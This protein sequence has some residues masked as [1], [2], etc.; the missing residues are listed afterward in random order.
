MKKFYLLI[1]TVVFLFSS[2]FSK[3]QPPVTYASILSN[4][5]NY[6]LDDA[7]FW[8]GSPGVPPPNPCTNCTIVINSD[9]TVVPDNGTSTSTAYPSPGTPALSDIKLDGCILQVNGGVT[10]TVNTYIE[11][12]N[13]NLLIGSDPTTAATVILNDQADLIGTSTVQL[14]NINCSVNTNN[15]GTA[16]NGNTPNPING[17]H[18]DIGN[19]ITDVNPL[20]RSAGIFGIFAPPDASGYNYSYVLTANGIGKSAHF[21]ATQYSLNCD[22]TTSNVCAVGWIY[23]PA[24]TSLDPTY[25]VIFGQAATLPVVLVQFLATKNPDATIKLSWAT[26]QEINSSSFDVERSADQGSWEKIG[27]VKAKGYAS[28]TSNYTFTDQFPLAGNGYYRL[29]MIDLDGKYEYSK[30]VFVTSDNISQPL[31][32][33]SNPFSDQIRLKV[34]VD[35]SQNLTLVVSDVIGKTYLK[36]SYHAQAGDNLINLVPTGAASGMY[37]LHIEGNTYDQTV[38]LAKQ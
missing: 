16:A 29:K 27:S 34:N 18:T 30:V 26:A 12:N 23:G 22:G 1:L 35:R 6:T 31:V 10:L 13:S 11:L 8:Q 38:K 5:S 15:T 20:D 3:A 2:F 14:A 4:P 32:V 37:V 9:V 19:P 25:G 17:P 28:T 24:V 33:Y 36:Q 21:Y 7:R